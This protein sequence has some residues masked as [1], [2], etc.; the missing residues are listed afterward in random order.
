MAA[1]VFQGSTTL[2]LDG[3]GRITVPA[4]HRELLHKLCQGRL[5]LTRHPDGCVLLFPRCAW[6]AFGAKVMRESDNRYRR[7][8]I[9]HAQDVEIDSGE[10]IHISPELRE[11]AHLSKDVLLMGVGTYF[12]I[13]DPAAYKAYQ[14]QDHPADRPDDPLS[15][16][17]YSYDDV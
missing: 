7:N 6:E 16:F 14:L 5:T 8:Y 12:E 13:W 15:T 17:T 3:K 11:A 2:S 10:R 1:V 9:G 4:R